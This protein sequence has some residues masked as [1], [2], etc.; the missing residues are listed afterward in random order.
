M[1]R[2]NPEQLPANL[3]VPEDDG[4]SSHLIG[5]PLPDVTLTSTS[6]APVNLSNKAGWLVIYCYPLTGKPGMSL[7]DQWDSIP[8]ARGCTPQACAF[9]DHHA[10]LSALDATV[11]AISTQTSSYQLEMASRLHLNFEVLSD[12]DLQFSSA[13]NLPMMQVSDMTL[14]RRLTMICNESTIRQVHY[15]VFPPDQDAARVVE[16]LREHH[17]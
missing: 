4:A 5:K 9:R 12:A 10:E 16:W 2:F 14:N 3:P 6:G 8:G 1:N 15:P 11:F 7:P 17:Q 13:L